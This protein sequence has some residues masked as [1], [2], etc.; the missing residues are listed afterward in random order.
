MGADG[1]QGLL[2]MRKAGARTIS[3]NEQTCVVYG[4]PR[5]AERLNAVEQVLPLHGIPAAIVKLVT[6]G[7]QT[8]KRSA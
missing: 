7:S 8:I 3:Q 5:E 6:R 1:A 4:M 2:S